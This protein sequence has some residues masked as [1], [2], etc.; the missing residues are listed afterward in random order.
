MEEINLIM[1]RQVD[2]ADLCGEFVTLE[3]AMLL[4]EKNMIDHFF[5]TMIAPWVQKHMFRFSLA[6]YQTR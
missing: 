5:Y 1:K 2:K 3:K 6:T 4:Q